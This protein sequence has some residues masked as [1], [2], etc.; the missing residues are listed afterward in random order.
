MKLHDYLKSPGALTVA[1]LREAIG[2]RNDDQV[3]QWQHGYA[4][5]LPSPENC[6]AIERA[7]EG[8]V[9]CEELRPDDAW[10]RIKD[11][12]WPWHPKGRPVLDVA[13]EVV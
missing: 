3:R 6:A 4:G 10:T 12:A 7:T 5:R 11:R 8:A 9:T 1:Q 13:R 2:A